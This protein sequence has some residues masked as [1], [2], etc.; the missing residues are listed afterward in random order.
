MAIPPLLT[1]SAGV[2][3]PQ[4]A[5]DLAG[6]PGPEV[7]K[8]VRTALEVGYRAF[9]VTGEAD[10]DASDVPREDLFV[11]TRPSVHGYDAVLRAFDGRSGFD[12]V[13]LPGLAAD[14][15]GT[16][17]ALVRLREEGRTR[18]IGAADLPE[19]V[20]RRLIDETGVVPALH[21]VELHPWRQQV[22]LREFHGER[23]I[24]T[25]ASSPLGRGSL[26][27]DETVTALAAK[28]GKT[29]AQIVLRWHLQLGTVAV[30]RAEPAATSRIREHLEI[31][32]FELADDDLV[33][34]A[35]LDS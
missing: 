3:I 29:P 1:L 15:V 33:V 17:R 10:L 4:L 30:L 12:L 7:A 6:V 27:A 35:E 2:R 13:L 11:A 16:W 32:D 24:V 25:A 18:A 22:P 34:L 14:F 26:L 31:T 19:S 20:L 23:G 21:Q 9:E 8:A 5:Y 28:Y